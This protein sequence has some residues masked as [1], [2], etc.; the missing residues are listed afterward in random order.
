MSQTL[1][2]P[3][4]L[5]E[6]DSNDVFFVR[7]AL[8][9]ALIQNPVEVFDRAERAYEY[10]GRTTALAPVLIILDINLAGAQTGLDVLAWIRQLPDPLGSTPVLMLT[11]SD[12]Q[13]ERNASG[14]LGAIDFLQK[15]ATAESLAMAVQALGFSVVNNVTTGQLGIHIVPSPPVVPLPARGAVGSSASWQETAPRFTYVRDDDR[16]RIRVTAL[17]ALEAADVAAVVERQASEGTWQFDIVYDLRAVTGATTWIDAKEAVALVR[18]YVIQHG[19]RGRVAVVTREI[20]MVGIAQG[21]AYETAKSGIDV[22]IFW[23]VSDAVDWLEAT[24][25]NRQQNPNA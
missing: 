7:H 14:H 10:L 6:D 22:Q 11:G 25:P 18:R 4:I 5:V 16:R 23:D 20:A 17:V 3:I 8:T 1:I 19:R 15:P 2:A 13:E 24:T 12:G 21:Y 9:A